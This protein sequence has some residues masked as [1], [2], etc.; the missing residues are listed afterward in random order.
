MSKTATLGGALLGGLLGA[1]PGIVFGFYAR[2]VNPWFLDEPLSF[3]VLLILPTTLLGLLLGFLLGRRADARDRH[4]GRALTLKIALP[5]AFATLFALLSTLT[6]PTPAKVDA[7]LVIVGIDGATWDLIDPMKLPFLSALQA[8]STRAVLLSREPM[9]SPLLWNTMA[10]GQTPEV[11]GIHGFRVRGDQS[12]SA[13]W[14]DVAYQQGYRI[15]LYKWLVSWPPQDLSQSTEQAQTLAPAR[16]DSAFYL[17]AHE[18]GRQGFVVPAWLAPSPET[19]PADLSFVKEIEL[20]RRI[21]RKA[22]DDARP[23]WRL[24]W[25]GLHRGFRWSTLLEAA[26]WS[27][28]E[29]FGKPRPEER[30]WRLNLLRVAMDRDVFIHQLHMHR[31]DVASFTMYST[32]A[33]GHTH[34]GFMD[35][36]NKGTRPCDDLARALP[37]AYEQADQVLYEIANSVED[38]TTILVVS[39]HG[40]RAMGDEDA[41]R[42]FAPRTERLK[43]IL[44]EQVGPVDVSK[45]GH[46]L[47]VAMLGEDVEAEKARLVAFLEGQIQ[48]ST[49]KPFYRW[50]EVPDSPRALGL[51]LADERVDAERLAS[52]TVGGE[53]LAEFAALTDAYSGEHDVKGILLARG[54]GIPAGQRIEP[55]ALLDLAPT[56]LALIGAPAAADMPGRAV[57][58]ETLP[59]VA[60]WEA[61]APIGKGGAA[62]GEADVNEEQLRALGYIE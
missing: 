9:F 46:K 37:R 17:K 15:G 49:G 62:T 33:L 1:L 44:Q 11:H 32:D 56:I 2:R 29:R 36:C 18:Q 23:A 16:A 3:I 47:V 4:P 60:T 39:D 61:L 8:E 34:F 10:T 24:A 31:P 14:W 30:T 35:E 55:V 51:T 12:A 5:F 6:A 22:I 53:S 21:K 43:A 25:D 28:V 48:A 26:R 27:L 50:E 13:R 38:Q 19:W 54:P 45:A 40:F 20:S 52:D 57:F 59:R 58:G 7:K 41:G 42:Y